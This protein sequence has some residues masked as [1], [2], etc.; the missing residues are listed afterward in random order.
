MKFQMGAMSMGDILDRGL[1]LLLARL[2]TFYL[3]NL[4]VLSPVLILRLALPDLIKDFATETLERLQLATATGNLLLVLISLMLQPIATA[5]ILHVV[6][7]EFVGQNATI[8]QALRFALRRFGTLL[9]ASIM[10]GVLVAV[11]SFLVA[12]PAIALTIMLGPLIGV[13]VG[14]VAAFVLVILV[15]VYYVFIAQVI[16]VENKGAASALWRSHALT[17]GYRWQVLGLFV[18]SFVITLIFAFSLAIFDQLMP[19]MEVVTTQSGVKGIINRTNYSVHTLIEALLNILVQTFMA[20]C[21]TL[22]YFNIRIRK[23]GYDLEL[24][25]ASESPVPT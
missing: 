10:V 21:F 7:Q 25:T 19:Y 11:L 20:V 8:G 1:K 5:A 14:M 17:S 12:M 3:I 22:L 4:I 18:L 6:A 16:V 24:A 15:M 9:L 13:L 2:G 23:E